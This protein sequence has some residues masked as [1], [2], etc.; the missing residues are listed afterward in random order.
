MNPILNHLYPHYKLYVVSNG[1]K[2]IQQ[3]RIINS[4]LNKYFKEIIITGDIGVE[5]PDSKIFSSILEKHSKENILFIGD[6]LRDDY[7]GAQNAEIEFCFYNRKGIKHNADIKF[8]INCLM[9][10]IF[11]VNS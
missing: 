6:S 8:E 7:I 1:L 4:G 11:L 10:L 9:D 2:K 5:K 3:I